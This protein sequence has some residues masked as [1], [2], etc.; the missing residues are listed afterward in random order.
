MSDT[1]SSAHIP[2]ALPMTNID[3]ITDGFTHISKRTYV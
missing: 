1:C 2:T 3:G